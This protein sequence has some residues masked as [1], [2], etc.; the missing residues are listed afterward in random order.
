M[1]NPARALWVTLMFQLAFVQGCA[2]T[3]R[4]RTLC[5]AQAHE[6]AQLRRVAVLPFGGR[7]GEKTRA[8]VEALMVSVRID[9]QPFFNVIERG[10]IDAVLQ[11]QRLQLSAAVDEKTAVS[12]GRILGAEAVV[13]GSVTRDKVEDKGYKEQRSKCT[14]EDKKGNCKSWSEYTVSCTERTTYFDFVPRIVDVST[15]RIVASDIIDGQA[16]DSKCSDSSSPLKTR[17]ELAN[18]AQKL[19][20]AEY[21]RYIAPYYEDVEI[22]LITE[23]DSKMDETVRQ[24][25]DAGK[26]WAKEGRLDRACEYWREAYARHSDGYSLSYLVGVCEEV[27][28]NPEKAEA[29]YL[30]ADRA[31]GKPVDEI[32]NGLLRVRAKAEDKRRL[33]E[34]MEK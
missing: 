21:R 17:E 16:K 25:I 13:L 28:G 14:S 34:Q 22:T 2:T 6:A 15:A 24:K 26:T 32:T 7:G 30:K 20:M 5:A 3:V 9:G 8:D 33:K 23:D 10:A 18:E 29:L 31:S 1:R 12:L 19:A 4:S 27:G 11:E